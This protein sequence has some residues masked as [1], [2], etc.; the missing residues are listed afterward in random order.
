MASYSFKFCSI[1]K[2]KYKTVSPDIFIERLKK[3]RAL[4]PGLLRFDGDGKELR[5]EPFS[6]IRRFKRPK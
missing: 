2:D 3:L 6:E 5:V 1:V 4:D